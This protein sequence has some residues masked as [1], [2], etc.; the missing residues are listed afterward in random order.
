MK[1]YLIIYVMTQTAETSSLTMYGIPY[2]VKS[3]VKNTT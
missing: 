3:T 1:I 2:D